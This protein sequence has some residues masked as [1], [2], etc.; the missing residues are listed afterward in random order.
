[1]SIIDLFDADNIPED[2]MNKLDNTIIMKDEMGEEIRFE[3]LDLIKYKGRIFVVL[4]P[5]DKDCMEV[6]ILE[7]IEGDDSETEEYVSVVD[8]AVFAAVFEIFEKRNADKF[9]FI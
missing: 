2:E 8:D 5:D 4:L 1:M 9:N 7:Y 6:D 3:F